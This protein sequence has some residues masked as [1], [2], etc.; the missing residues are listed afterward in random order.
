MPQE[1]QQDGD[2]SMPRAVGRGK[3]GQLRRVYTSSVFRP[4]QEKSKEWFVLEQ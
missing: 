4:A 1:Y 2:K 3:K